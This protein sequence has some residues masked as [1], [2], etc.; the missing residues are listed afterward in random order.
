MQ[1]QDVCPVLLATDEAGMRKTLNGEKSFVQRLFLYS[2]AE[3][4]EWV[5]K[6]AML[7]LSEA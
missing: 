5:W 2:E 1:S 4:S 6:C 7:R 3:V